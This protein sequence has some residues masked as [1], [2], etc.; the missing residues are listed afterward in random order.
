LI[1]GGK[2]PELFGYFIYLFLA[3]FILELITQRKLAGQGK[4][5]LAAVLIVYFGLP[6]LG[7]LL[8]VFDLSNTTKRGLFKLF[9]LI[10]L[11]LQDNKLLINLSNK[12]EAWEKGR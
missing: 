1:F 2:G 7:Y 10:L 8:P 5:W 9:P 11:Y 6:V 12:I 4:N 3:A